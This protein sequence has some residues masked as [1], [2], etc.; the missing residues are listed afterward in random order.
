M[1]NCSC[2]TAGR[3]LLF[4][5]WYLQGMILVQAAE[6]ASCVWEEVYLYLQ[7]TQWNGVIYCISSPLKRRNLCVGRFTEFLFIETVFVFSLFKPSHNEHGG[8]RGGAVHIQEIEK[9][10]NSSDYPASGMPPKQK[11][12]AA[13]RRSTNIPPPRTR[14]KINY[15]RCW[16]YAFCCTSAACFFPYSVPG[17][18][19][20]L[21]IFC[22]HEANLKPVVEA[23]AR[24]NHREVPCLGLWKRSFRC[25]VVVLVKRCLCLLA[26]KA[27]QKLVKHVSS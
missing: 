8:M 15:T 21:F 16:R 4:V 20:F 14:Q 9:A 5:S 23:I 1:T 2:T 27:C 13:Q 17:T 3:K 6:D 11:K 24:G 12:S 10:R 19:F 26:R 18:F 7:G 25:R 22:L